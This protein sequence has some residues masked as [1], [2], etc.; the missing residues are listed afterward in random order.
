MKKVLYLSNIEVPYRVAFFNELAK[1]C[2]LTVVY[3]RTKSKTRDDTWAASEK[4]NYSSVFLD[5]FKISNESAFSFKLFRYLF[6]KNDAIIVGC[7]NS[8]A[9]TLAIL[10][11]RLLRIRYYLNVDGEPFLEGS[12]IKKKLKRFVVRGAQKYFTAGEKSAEAVRRI[13][14]DR[15]IIPYYFSSHSQKELTEI[16]RI[17]PAQRQ[18]NTV[19]IVGQYLDVKGLDVALQVAEQDRERTYKFIGMGKRTELF[20]ETYNPKRLENVEIIPFLQKKDLE[21]EYRKCALFVLPSR[22][23]CWGLVINEAA[24]FGTP[25]VSTW[26]SGAAVEF[27][28]DAYPDFLASPGDAQELRTCIERYFAAKDKEEYSEFLFE[29]ARQYHIEKSVRAHLAAIEK[30]GE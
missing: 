3:E 8:P 4:Q 18:N 28:S 17:P 7:Y 20:V 1:H 30:N 26:G 9:Q 15:E 5:G 10:L 24:S 29:K 19:L 23:E 13:V 12:G 27:L 11:M 6:Q 22:Q 2:D 25:M 21:E 14:G 16:Q